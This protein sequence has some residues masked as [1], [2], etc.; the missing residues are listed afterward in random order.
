M[1][2]GWSFGRGKFNTGAPFSPAIVALAQEPAGHNNANFIDL[3]YTHVFNPVITYAN[4]SM[5]AWQTGVPAN[6][7]GGIVRSGPDLTAGTAHWPSSVQYL[8]FTLTPRLSSILRF[9]TFDDFNGQRTGFPGLYETPTA[10]IQLR[11]FEGIV[12]RPELRYDYNVQS[13]PFEGKHY[14]LTAAS[15]LIIRW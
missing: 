4:G 5:Y 13:R 14:L 15:D 8:R 6:V 7:P 12:I 3:V 9:E 10:G 2:L 11:L 1:Q